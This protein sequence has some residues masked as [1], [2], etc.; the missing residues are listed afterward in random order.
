MRFQALETSL[1]VIRALRGPVSSLRI[2]DAKLCDQIRRA[3]SS[4]TLNIAEGA[5]RTGK[6][7]RQRYRIA[8]GSAEEVRAGL[9]VALAWGELRAQDVESALRLIDRLLAMLWK[10][11]H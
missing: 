4:V 8:A 11:T 2:R 7:R 5:G 10:M 1:D 6:D 9:R 3:A